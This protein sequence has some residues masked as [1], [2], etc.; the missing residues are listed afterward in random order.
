M[1][2]LLCVFTIHRGYLESFWEVK[3]F[4]P[5]LLNRFLAIL[6]IESFPLSLKCFSSLPGMKMDTVRLKMEDEQVGRHIKLSTNRTERGREGDRERWTE[7]EGWFRLEIIHEVITN[8]WHIS[9]GLWIPQCE[10]VLSLGF[11]DFL[12]YI[13]ILP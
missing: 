10:H 8:C 11:Q 1:T 13:Y 4:F 6:S 3:Y 12:K 7:N 2:L 9:W 5:P